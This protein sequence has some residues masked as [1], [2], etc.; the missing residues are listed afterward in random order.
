M[1]NSKNNYYI[2]RYGVGTFDDGK[3]D[4]DCRGFSGDGGAQRWTMDHDNDTPERRCKH[5]EATTTTTKWKEPRIQYSRNWWGH[6]LYRDG[7]H[8]EL[9][10]VHE[11]ARAVNT[12]VQDESRMER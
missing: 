4:D 10:Q 12:A 11:L 5:K 8:S 7:L 2:Q 1:R 6:S 3:D 9:I